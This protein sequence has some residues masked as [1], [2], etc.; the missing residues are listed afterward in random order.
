[1]Q[2]Y[3]LIWRMTGSQVRAFQANVK[4]AENNKLPS[5]IRYISDDI[6]K[7]AMNITQNSE[8]LIYQLHRMARNH[9]RRLST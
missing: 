5:A 1:M 3:F 6:V 4:Y 8:L 9:C 7:F 2:I